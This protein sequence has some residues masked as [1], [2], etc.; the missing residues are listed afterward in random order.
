MKRGEYREAAGAVGE[1]LS[2]GQDTKKRQ[3]T[4]LSLPRSQTGRLAPGLAPVA[5]RASGPGFILT[6]P[7]SPEKAGATH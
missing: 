5:C 6:A 2:V 1:P 4:A 3:G 7:P